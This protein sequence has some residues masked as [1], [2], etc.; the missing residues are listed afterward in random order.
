[1]DWNVFN[2]HNEA[3]DDAFE[4]MCV[5]LF[6]N[7]VNRE[8]G[9]SGVEVHAVNGKGGDGGVEAYA[10]LSTGGIVGVQAK[11]FR[12]KIGTTQIKQIENSFLTAIK[13][14]PSLKKYIIFKTTTKILE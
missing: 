8:Y 10:V 11:W 6:K 1:M 2:T 9:Q 7:W 5:L 14:R 13:I 12:S 3:P 4:T